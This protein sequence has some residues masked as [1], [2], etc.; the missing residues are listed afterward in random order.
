MFRYMKLA[1]ER[2]YITSPSLKTQRQHSIMHLSDAVRNPAFS[3]CWV[4]IVQNT[5]R[6]HQSLLQISERQFVILMKACILRIR[7]CYK[8][9]WNKGRTSIQG[10]PCMRALCEADSP[11]V[12]SPGCFASLRSVQGAAPLAPLMRLSLPA[13]DG[14]TICSHRQFPIQSL[15]LNTQI[16][17][18]V[19]KTGGI[20]IYK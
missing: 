2:M 18:L 10:K 19:R 15:K 16:L 13:L 12:G 6:H 9:L 14:K 20:F 1:F 7:R 17:P 11:D 3:V 8:S 4:Y 5:K